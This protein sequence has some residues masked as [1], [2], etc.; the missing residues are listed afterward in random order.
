MSEIAN[1]S[2]TFSFDSAARDKW[3]WETLEKLVQERGY[4]SQDILRNYPAYIMRRDMPRFLSHYELFKQ[5]IDL[6]GCIVELGVFRGAS[7]FTWSKFMEIFCPYD[8]SRKVFGFDSFGGLQQFTEKDGAMDASVQKVQEGYKA[9]A[10]EVQTLVELH[11]AD[12]MIPG[13]KRCKIIIGD[14]TE[15]LPKFLE[16]QP[17]LKISLLHFDVDLYQP[18]KFALELLYPYVLKGGVVCFDE[19]GLIPWQGETKAVD[20]FFANVPNPPII[21][22]HPFAQTPHGYFIK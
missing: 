7:F 3:Y 20:E 2:N 17:G 8:R 5:V 13:T 19:Y 6:P 11:N 1:Q 21:K 4:T 18:T 10:E 12:N 9:T 16:E 15:T 14:L 22:K